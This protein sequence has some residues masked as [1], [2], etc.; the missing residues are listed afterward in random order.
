MFDETVDEDD[1]CNVNSNESA[2]NANKTLVNQISYKIHKYNTSN[3][4]SFENTLNENRDDTTKE[5]KSSNVQ[6]IE[7]EDE[8]SNVI[9]DLII[10]LIATKLPSKTRICCPKG[11]LATAIGLLSK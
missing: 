7:K 9:Q 4:S 3:V 2:V 6:R 11:N 8:R 1:A 5:N 10:I